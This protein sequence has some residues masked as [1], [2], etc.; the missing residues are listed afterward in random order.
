[1]TS[2]DEQPKIPERWR[3][4]YAEVCRAA[5]FFRN[6]DP[7]PA[8]SL[9]EELGTAEAR[10][11]ELEAQLDALQWTPITAE[12]MPKQGD[13]LLGRCGNGVYYVNE[14]GGLADYAQL[15]AEEEWTHFRPINAPQPKAAPSDGERTEGR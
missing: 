11:A 2:S 13:E 10:V 7:S 12:N 15:V 6:T 5:K 3:Q 9:I 14:Y 1:M 4:F 8:K